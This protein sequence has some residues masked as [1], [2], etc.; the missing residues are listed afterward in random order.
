MAADGSYVKPE[1]QIRS[2]VKPQIDKEETLSLV[3]IGTAETIG[4]MLLVVG[5]ASF[6][7]SFL[8]SF[9]LNYLWGIINGI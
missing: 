9:A 1:K 8:L 5:I 2:I 6:M 7:M 3:C 4:Q